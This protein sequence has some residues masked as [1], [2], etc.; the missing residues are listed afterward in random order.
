MR[1]TNVL[2]CSILCAA[3]CVPPGAVAQ[4]SSPKPAPKNH[5]YQVVLPVTV[6]DKHGALVTNL[7]KSDLTLTEDGRVQAI[8]SLTRDST[9]PFRVGL[10]FDTS[11]SMNGALPE[12]R[13]AAETFLGQLL[14][15]A[16]GRNQAFLIHFDREVELLQDFTDS[17]EKIARELDDMGSTHP[18]QADDQ[19]P[20]TSDD[21]RSARRGRDGTQLYDAI[22]LASDELMK[23][24][25]GNKALIVFSNGADH[26]SKE[27]MNEAVDAADH[28]GLTVYTIF[29]KGEQENNASR[30]PGNNRRGGM[31]YPGGGYPG[32][33]GGY[34]GGGRRTPEPTTATGVDGKKIMQEIATRTGGHAYEAHKAADLEPIFKLI[35]EELQGQYLLTYTPDKPDTDG[36][37]HKIALTAG[38]KDWKVAVREGYYAPEK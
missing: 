14:P 30:M 26:G 12:E 18:A 36:D 5:G 3:A 1:T 28:A 24:K 17:R 25:D 20:E 31:G 4:Q 29:F 23:G 19:G 27:T 7:Q 2:F 15:S 38:N 22:Y 33:G 10:L 32:G 16:P 37:F 8:Q 11:R 13:K 35:D 6:R 34:P 9:L 21:Q